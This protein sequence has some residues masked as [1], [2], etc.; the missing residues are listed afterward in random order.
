MADSI[1]TLKPV[2][3]T[4]RTG[5]SC[6][7]S[8][9]TIKLLEAHTKWTVSGDSALSVSLE[10]KT[11]NEE[12]VLHLTRTNE[13]SNKDWN[14]ITINLLDGDNGLVKLRIIPR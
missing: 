5:E 8:D 1:N 14:T 12:E 13:V 3:V 7:I 9:I 11:K 2:E 6:K 4:L 10:V